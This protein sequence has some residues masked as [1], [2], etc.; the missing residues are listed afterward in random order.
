MN[1][2]LVRLSVHLTGILI[3]EISQEE[4]VGFIGNDQCNQQKKLIRFWN[5]SKQGQGHSKNK[6]LF[7]FASFL[8][9]KYY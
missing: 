9:E 8:C 6:C 2:I 4:L 7:S 1:L 3:S 5:G